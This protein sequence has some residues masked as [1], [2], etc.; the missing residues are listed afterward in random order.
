MIGGLALRLLVELL[1]EPTDPRYCRPAWAPDS[2]RY[3]L[4]PTPP[5]PPRG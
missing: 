3:V 5:P 4:I 1:G 2:D